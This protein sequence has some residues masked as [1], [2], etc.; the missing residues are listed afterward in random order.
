MEDGAA[1]VAS[2]GELAATLSDLGRAR[3][4][5]RITLP[6][7]AYLVSR[8]LHLKSHNHL[9]IPSSNSHLR[10]TL[11]SYLAVVSSFH[12]SIHHNRPNNG[13]QCRINAKPPPQYGR[14]ELR[15]SPQTNSIRGEHRIDQIIPAVVDPKGY[16]ASASTAPAPPTV[17]IGCIHQTAD[18]PSR[19]RNSHRGRAERVRSAGPARSASDDQYCRGLI[20]AARRQV[21]S[22]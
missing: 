22:L 3:P 19:N 1:A 5:D 7:A 2:W 4:P 8:I 13:P 11:P 6:G 16:F 14:H 12:S 10:H 18:E 9:A 20:V 17:W 15:H 21:R